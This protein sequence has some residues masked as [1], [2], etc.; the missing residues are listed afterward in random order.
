MRQLNL[1][2]AL[3]EDLSVDWFKQSNPAFLALLSPQGM[4]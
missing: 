1:Y 3:Q 2:D 4:K